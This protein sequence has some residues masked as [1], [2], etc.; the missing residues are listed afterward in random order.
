MNIYNIVIFNRLKYISAN[1]PLHV[2][3]KNCIHNKAHE[4]NGRLSEFVMAFSKCLQ[5]LNLLPL[6]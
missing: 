5:Y 2:T 3:I 6:C 1:S 4:K